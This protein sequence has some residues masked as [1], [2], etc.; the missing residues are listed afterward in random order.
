MVILTYIAR[1]RPEWQEWNTGGFASSRHVDRQ[2]DREIHC[3]LEHKNVTTLSL[4]GCLR[5][6]WVTKRSTETT[7]KI[8]LGLYFDCCSPFQKW[9]E[10]VP[11][12]HRHAKGMDLIKLD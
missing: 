2:T 11:C 12:F 6:R 4:I 3:Q 9:A 8:E 10:L 7:L 5:A 1:L